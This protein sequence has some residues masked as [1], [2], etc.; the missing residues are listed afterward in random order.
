[1]IAIIAILAAI[2]FPVFA[3]AR[4]KARAITC[5]SNERQLGLAFE[6]YVQDN[7]ETL[8]THGGNGNYV[9]AGWAGQ[10]FPYV[11]NTGVYGCPDDATPAVL[12]AVPVSYA[13]NLL[14]S[15]TDNPAYGIGGVT[16]RLTAPAQTV[17][18]LEVSDIDTPVNDPHEQPHGGS[19]S[20]V[21]DGTAILSDGPLGAVGAG[22]FA[23]G[24]LGDRPSS[25]GQLSYPSRHAAGSNFL[26]ADGHV[27]WLAP[28]QV[29]TG[30]QLAIEPGCGQD[31]AVAGCTAP[32]P[33]TP[34]GTANPQYAATV[35]P[36]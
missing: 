4:E 3:Q 24:Y 2:L 28:T 15:R 10:I 8:P 13:Y 18:L 6:Q 30:W 36:N 27:K 16:A 31:S 21:T 9:G 25:F 29:S 17:L 32:S 22:V 1:M 12:P 23:T 33:L 20:A 35:S 11:K 5:A 19:Y 34:A 26:L 14:I 7:D